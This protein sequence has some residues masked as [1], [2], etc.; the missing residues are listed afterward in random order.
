[1]TEIAVLIADGQ[2]LIRE[3]LTTLLALAPDLRVVGQ[4]AGGA[5]AV[6]L[7]RRRQPDVVLLDLHLPGADNT[8]AI[9]AIR[10]GQPA[11]QILI[12]T[13]FADDEA[14]PAALRAGACGSLLKD[15]P[16]GQL[17]EAI[18]AA[19]ASVTQRKNKKEEEK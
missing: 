1:M 17:A 16:S 7:A 6:E 15:R 4:A 12:L 8:A 14:L 3:G 2:P 13:T 19:V 5:E 9:R 11:T 10:A 18:R